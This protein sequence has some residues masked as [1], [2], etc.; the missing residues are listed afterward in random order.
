MTAWIHV[1]DLADCYIAA[2]R[3]GS[4]G[5]HYLAAPENLSIS[6]I[7]TLFA[8]AAQVEF[9]APVFENKHKVIFDDSHTREILQLQWKYKV[10]DLT[11]PVKSLLQAASPHRGRVTLTN[12]ATV[13]GYQ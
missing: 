2:A 13:P 10:A 6:Q 3:K 4:K 11:F 9:F 7:S 5:G 1:E 8:K 12:L